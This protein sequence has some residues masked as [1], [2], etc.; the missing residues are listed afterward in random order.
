MQYTAGPKGGACMAE[1]KEY[2]GSCHCGNVRYTVSLDLSAP[3]TAC[4]CSIC[5][6]TGTLLT[7]VPQGQFKLERGEESLTDY[8]FNKKVIHHLFCKTCRVRSFA[9]GTGPDGKEMVAI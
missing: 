4:N 1:V 8:Q 5:G 9:R 3:A 7:F 2:V 6:R